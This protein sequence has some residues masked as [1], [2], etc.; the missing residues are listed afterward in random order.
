MK[1]QA[2]E[3]PLVMSGF[4]PEAIRLWQKQMAGTG[5][6]M[7][8]AGGMGGGS[9]GSGATTGGKRIRRYRPRRWPLWCRGRR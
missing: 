3:T 5:L 4:R 7:V 9:V 1:F 2:M 6:E 8:A